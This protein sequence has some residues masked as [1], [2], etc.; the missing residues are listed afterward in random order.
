MRYMLMLYADEKVGAKIPPDQMAKAMDNLFAYQAALTKAGAFVMTSPLALTRDARTIRMEGGEVHANG[1][2]GGNQ[3]VSDGEMKVH[4]GPYA[5]TREQ[6]GGFYIIEAEDMDKALEWAKQCP[7]AQWGSV[8][9]RAMVP[10]FDSG[11]A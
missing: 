8:E 3:F 4:D 5:E 9:V 7:A 2:S 6:L 11:P 1:G 10:G